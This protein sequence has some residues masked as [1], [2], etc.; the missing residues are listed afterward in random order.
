MISLL[1][2]CCVLSEVLNGFTFHQSQG[3]VKT[4]SP[5]AGSAPW[6]PRQLFF[7]TI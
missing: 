7:S 1:A 3:K 4:L 2:G 5:F 6:F